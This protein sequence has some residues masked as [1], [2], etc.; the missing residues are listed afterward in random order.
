MSEIGQIVHICN[1]HFVHH[2]VSDR[3]ITSIFALH[4]SLSLYNYVCL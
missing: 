3:E 1:C 4:S 2:D